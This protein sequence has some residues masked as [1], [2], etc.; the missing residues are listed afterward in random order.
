[1][2]K[3]LRRFTPVRRDWTGAAVQLLQQGNWVWRTSQRHS[4]ASKIWVAA[5]MQAG[6]HQGRL[7]KQAVAGDVVT[8]DPAAARR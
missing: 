6:L 7:C 4:R 2:T 3:R 8:D 1:M 5:T